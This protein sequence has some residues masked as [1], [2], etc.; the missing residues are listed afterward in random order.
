MSFRVEKY[1]LPVEDNWAKTT[2]IPEDLRDILAMYR[3]A[4][5]DRVDGEIPHADL[6]DLLETYDGLIGQTV[7]ASRTD[8][9]AVIGAAS[10]DLERNHGQQAFFEGIAVDPDYRRQG[11][12]QA[13]VRV[14]LDDAAGHGHHEMIARSQPSSLDANSRVLGSLGV[15]FSVDESGQYPRIAMKTH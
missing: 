2:D 8:T 12:A 1:S 7:L 6:D 10:Y 4:L 13:M 5:T 3:M 11:V 9:G 14:A 15:K